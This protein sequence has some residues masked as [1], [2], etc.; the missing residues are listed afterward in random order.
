MAQTVQIVPQYLHS[1][2]ET[3][4]NDYTGF[5]DT[6]NVQ[7][8]DS[9]KFL[10]VFMGPQGIDNTLIKVE[11]SKTFENIFGKSNYN[12][13]GQPM[14]MPEA[15]LQTG[16]ASCWC[17]RIMPVD[18]Y[19]A[20]S[21]LSLYYKADVEN[22]K[23]RIKFKAKSFTDGSA[24]TS[25]DDLQVKG[26]TLDGEPSGD[27]DTYVDAD[28]YTQVPLITFRMSGRGAYGNNYRWR[29]ARSKDYEA[30]YQIK[31]YAFETLNASNGISQTAWYAG[32]LVDSTKYTETLLINDVIDDA[33]TGVAP[34]DVRVYEDNMELVYEAYVAFLQA[35][36]EANPEEVINIPDNDEFDPFFGYGVA[37]DDLDPYI[38]FT[39][40]KDDTVDEEDE[41]YDENDYS[42][43][44]DIIQIDNVEG[45]SLAGGSDGAFANE[46][47]DAKDAAIN[48]AY[49]N[50]FNGTYDPTILA[51]KRTRCDAI[52]D[53]DYAYEVK[54][55][56][57]DLALMRNDCLCFLDCGMVT[58]FS[59]ANQQ[60]LINDYGS[61]NTRGIS[62][63]PQWYVIKDPIT[64]K[65]HPV[66]ITYFFA[67]NYATHVKTNGNHVPF[68]NSYAQL[69]GHVK[70]SLQ[71]CIEEHEMD[72]KEWLYVNRFN[73]FEAI[74]ENQFQRCC[75]NT[76]Q[77]D[78]SD[79]MEENNMAVLFEMKHILEIDAR[80]NL[81]NFAN[82]DD[83]KR[84][85]EY[86]TAKFA[87]W[88][89]R[90]L[91]SFTI[92]F[93]M[94]EWEAE[95]SILHCYVA[96]QFR[97][98]NKRTIIEIDVNKRDFTA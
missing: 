84:F 68:V 12:L 29:I 2:V 64:R 71:P 48:A 79:L 11:D 54:Q 91:Y 16:N 5:S 19:Y 21:V 51:N 61:F 39:K 97:T 41:N 65:K 89:G 72:L 98:L 73:Y 1:H 38:S 85:T 30:D 25:A 93:S 77:M 62:K 56:L 24:I 44:T 76:A 33:D 57:V 23:F 40:I 13:Y 42:T 74:G 34:M 53:A 10:A 69:S 63:N 9:V 88:V 95:R 83:R 87:N 22:K 67:Q 52:L 28:G 80:E 96:V 27:N 82:A 14:M 49:I 17:M 60:K 35:V 7:S 58:S 45:T 75:Q 86:E 94:N 15:E 6:T 43:D 47:A 8:D 4:I 37:N 46:D 50:A 3:Y 26:L 18:A 66:T 55:T 92:S 20:N 32:S 31:I 78:N 59:T 70:N 90:K 36:A 81:Y